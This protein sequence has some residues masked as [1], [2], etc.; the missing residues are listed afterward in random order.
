MLRFG[1]LL[2]A[3]SALA[4]AMPAQA[5][6]DP[7]T[8]AFRVPIGGTGSSTSGPATYAW[9]QNVSTCSNACGDGT[10]TTS[11]QCQNVSDYDFSGG[12]YGAPE[13]DSL[14]AS[15]KPSSTS[16]S[17][18]NYS[19][20][21]YDWV[22][23]AVSVTRLA[24][25]NPPS[26]SFPVGAIDSCSYAQRVFAPYCQRSGS[27]AVTLP[28]GD[29]A[30]CKNDTP[31][32]NDVANG[33]PDALGYD[34]TTDDSSGCVAGARD[35]EWKFS[36]VVTEP[37]TCSAAPVRVNEFQCVQR[38]NRASKPASFCSGV[39]PPSPG[40]NE[41]LP[42]D[43]SGCSTTWETGAWGSW[44][45][46]CSDSATRTRTVLCR[47]SDGTAV[48]D[49]QCI[50]TKPATSETGSNTVSCGYD[51]GT[52]S[53][54]T[55]ASSCSDSTTRTRTVSCVRTDGKTVADSNCTAPKPA[56]AETGVSNTGSCTY[57]PRDQGRTACSSEGTQQQYWDC[58]RSDGQTGFPA[59]YCGKTNPENLTCTPPPPTYTYTPVN[60]GESACSGGQKNVYWDCTRSDG[61]TGYPASMCGKTNPE[62]QTCVMPYTYTPQYRGETACSGGQKQVYWDCTRSDGQQGFPASNC[63]KTNPETQ[64]CTMPVTYSPRYQGETACSGGQ[65]QVYWDCL[66]SDGS[67]A[68]ASA[69]G[70][71]NPETQSC[72]MPVTYSWQTGGWSGYSSSCSDSA[73]RT[74]SV[75]C[76]GSDGSQ[77]GDG[78]CGG[79]KPSSSETTGVY[80]SCTYVSEDT[81][82]NGC[83]SGTRTYTTQCRRSDGNIV[84]NSNCGTSGTRTEAC[85]TKPA[86]C[87]DAIDLITMTWAGTTKTIS[88][89]THLEDY[90][91]Q[92]SQARAMSPGVSVRIDITNNGESK[93]IWG[94]YRLATYSGPQTTTWSDTVGG[95]TFTFRLGVVDSSYRL[96]MTDVYCN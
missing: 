48:A 68:P 23:P 41:T 62:T 85:S 80:S 32:Y 74:R 67:S 96:A 40:V 69:C 84:A 16:S 21:S 26:G 11:Y 7:G 14:C 18:T 79:G 88:R 75:W 52:P 15:A 90:N 19:G 20:C 2:A 59:S 31:D 35:H 63:G 38:Y 1:T 5:Q 87:G 65:K 55:Y 44:S 95:Y 17:C 43:Y 81:G 28:R 46:A 78:P 72:T 39:N 36:R 86:V 53:D 33:V 25:P 83:V 13:A 8:P 58:T 76:Q 45:S 30:F 22:K 49:S 12:G 51:W 3:A 50:G 27:P 37:S 60:R 10:R 24:K 93:T 92:G 77:P 42:A 64:S 47:R 6:T 91:M 4:F 94:S 57:T 61:A 9:M 73:T 89:N 54:W 34:R 56:T 71:T 70:K 82:N 66:G 29:Y